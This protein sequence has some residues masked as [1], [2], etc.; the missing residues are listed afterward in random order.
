MQ[1]GCHGR[2]K[3]RAVTAEE[4]RIE[5]DVP[6][7]PLTTLELGGAAERFV[8]VRS[9]RELSAAVELAAEN[10][11]PLTIL[12]G[13]SNVIVADGGVPG[14]VVRIELRGVTWS[15]TRE[16]LLVDVAAGEP[17]DG[18]VAAAVSQ[19]RAGLECLSG[20]PGSVGGTPVQNVGAYGVEVAERIESVRIFDVPNRRFA[21]IPAAD[22][23]FGYRASRFRG[24]RDAIV[25]SVR[26]VLP[27]TATAEARYPE[28]VRE[29]GGNAAPPHEVREAVLRLRRSKSMVI[30]PEDENHRS[31]GSF[32]VNPVVS[33]EVAD[34]AATAAAERLPDRTLPRFPAADGKVK[35]SA[36]FLIEAAGFRKGERRGAVGISSRH[37]LALVHHGGGTAAGLVAFARQ[38][39]DTVTERLGVN[40]RPEPVFLGFGEPPI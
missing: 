20:I 5:R 23:G 27:A 1:D 12:G 21:E 22:C 30:D 39:R 15:R 40:L 10:G 4:L 13:G 35:L 25:T 9:E 37:S 11:W 18:F 36:A 2:G 31:V 26:F 17:W 14:L 38:I 32:F 33:P 28:L 6:L 19:G 16:E 7:A 8:V 24:N 3:V 34:G 29:L